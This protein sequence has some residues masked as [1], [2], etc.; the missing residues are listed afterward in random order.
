MISGAA[1]PEQLSILG[2]EYDQ[3]G[4]IHVRENAYRIQLILQ[5]RS[6]AHSCTAHWLTDI[7]GTAT[8]IVFTAPN[9][10]CFSRLIEDIRPLGKSCL[11]TCHDF[12]EMI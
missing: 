8:L 2:G 11:L 6:G 1:T 12:I 10:P 5:F 3:E 7:R 9:R 4:N